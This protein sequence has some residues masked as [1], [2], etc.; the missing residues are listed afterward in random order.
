MT[1]VTPKSRSV[2]PGFLE[3][4]ATDMEALRKAMRGRFGTAN[5]IR[6]HATSGPSD[7]QDDGVNWQITVMALYRR[8]GT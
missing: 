4:A 5:G 2:E 1:L 7:P 6:V 8:Y 3:Q